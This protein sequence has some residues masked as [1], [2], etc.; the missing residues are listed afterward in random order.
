M[1]R[2]FL[3]LNQVLSSLQDEAE[4][5]RGGLRVPE[6]LLR[7]TDGGEPAAAEG[8]SRAARAQ[9]CEPL[10]HAPPGNHA[11]HVPLLRARRLQ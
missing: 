2:I 6:A 1:T 4:A 10:L 11:V 5:N 8:A 3:V 9:D 7:D